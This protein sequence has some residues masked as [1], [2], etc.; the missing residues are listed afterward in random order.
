MIVLDA[1]AAV[2]IL[3]G[4]PAGERWNERIL[5]R[6]EVA[7]VPHLLDVEVA[8]VLRRFAA[9]GEIDEARGFEALEDLADQSWLR[10]THHL[11]LTRIWELRANLSAYDATYVALAEALAAPLITADGRLTRAP[12]PRCEI[13]LMS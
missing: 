2:E 5:G 9:A 11:F 4:T 3:L 6:S 12:G 10:F 7:A 8:H 1:S 13:K